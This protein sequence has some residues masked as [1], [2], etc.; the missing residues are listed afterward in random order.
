M[1]AIL[2]KS[3]S[4]LAA[5]AVA[6]L[7][8]CITP[9]IYAEDNIDSQHNLLTVEDTDISSWV[10][11]RLDDKELAIR[12]LENS[13]L[14]NQLNGDIRKLDICSMLQH[15]DIPSDYIQ[16]SDYG[17]QISYTIDIPNTDWKL[18]WTL[19]N[20]FGNAIPHTAEYV[21]EH[22]NS[23]DQRC[24]YIQVTTGNYITFSTCEDVRVAKFDYEPFRVENGEPPKVIIAEG[25]SSA[26]SFEI[27]LA[28]LLIEAVETEA[29]ATTAIEPAQSTYPDPGAPLTLP[30]TFEK[31]VSNLDLAE[32]SK[33]ISAQ[34]DAGINFK[35][36]TASSILQAKTDYRLETFQEGDTTIFSVKDGLRRV[37]INFKDTKAYERPQAIIAFHDRHA[38][39]NYTATIDSFMDVTTKKLRVKIPDETLELEFPNYDS[40]QPNYFIDLPNGE[41]INS[42]TLAI[43][44]MLLELG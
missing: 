36:I 11:D 16:R 27:A 9:T 13:I 32:I 1:K 28:K 5:G 14:D 12:Q 42:E 35:E 2:K 34:L 41:Q 38:G 18:D 4:I 20:E 40:T 6:S 10:G 8:L 19:A 43:I 37:D 22:Y 3:L 33:D 26:T 39:C 31:A 7:S 24:G 15:L 44:A 29:C 25:E 23:N 30:Q 17:Y 21:L